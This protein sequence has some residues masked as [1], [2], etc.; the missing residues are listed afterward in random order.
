MDIFSTFKQLLLLRI[1]SD[2]HPV[3]LDTSKLAWGPS[4]FRFENAWLSH[5]TFKDFVLVWW[6][7]MVTQGWEGYKFMQR[8]QG[9]KVEVCKWDRKVFGNVELKFA[10][11]INR[12]KI[13]DELEDRGNWS[14]SLMED[15]RIAKCELEDSSFRFNKFQM[16]SQKGKM[17]W[18]KEGDQNSKF[19]HALLNNRR[20]E[21]IIERLEL[22]DGSVVSEEIQ[23]LIQLLVFI[24]IYLGNRMAKGGFEGL[25][26][27]PIDREAAEE[28]EKLFF[29]ELKKRCSKVMRK[30]TGAGWFYF[31]LLSKMLGCGQR[32]FIESV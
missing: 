26:W 27:S 9:L 28:L 4:L 24:R 16:E 15:R 7:S 14:A 31:G 22:E 29:E 32:R 5:K 25:E 6:N 12:I 21:A 20:N 11:L 18:L 23:L 1:T 13:L 17:R 10:E 19:F 30:I 2:H 8:I 3:L